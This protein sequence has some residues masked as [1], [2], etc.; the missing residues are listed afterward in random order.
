[1]LRPLDLDRY[2]EWTIEM[3]YKMLYP[4]IKDDFM[5]LGDC[6][7]V[8]TE[9]NMLAGETPVTH[10]TTRGGSSAKAN[11]KGVQ[12]RIDVQEGRTTLTRAKETG[13]FNG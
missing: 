12:Y 1:M 11:A 4:Y 9:G 13:D 6:G 2:K 10:I 8:H 5:G 7:L 3:L